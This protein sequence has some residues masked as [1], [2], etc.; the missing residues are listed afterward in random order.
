MLPAERHTNERQYALGVLESIGRRQDEMRGTKLHFVRIARQHG[1]TYD[2]IG[3][4]LGV[5]GP[6]IRKMLRRAGTEENN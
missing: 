2:E 5:T 6:A 1:A 4:A 3:H